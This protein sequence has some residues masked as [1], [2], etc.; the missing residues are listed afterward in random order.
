MSQPAN[1]GSKVWV[2]DAGPIKEKQLIEEIDKGG[3]RFQGEGILHLTAEIASRS[4]NTKTP[5]PGD[6]DSIR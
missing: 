3:V 5:L 2:T 4:H 6:R 1:G